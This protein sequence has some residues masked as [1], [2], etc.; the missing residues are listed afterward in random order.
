LTSKL[1]KEARSLEFRYLHLCASEDGINIYTE[2]GFAESHQIE[3][4]LK[5]E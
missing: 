4:R 1:I 3:L 2:V 5:L